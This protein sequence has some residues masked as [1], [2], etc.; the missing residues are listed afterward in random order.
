MDMVFYTKDLLGKKSV[1]DFVDFDN[2]IDLE[3]AL[4]SSTIKKNAMEHYALDRIWVP[5]NT[6]KDLAVMNHRLEFGEYSN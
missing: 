1:L 6:P 3:T 5:I 4:F 2:I